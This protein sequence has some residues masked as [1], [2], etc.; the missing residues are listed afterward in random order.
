[1]LELLKKE[2]TD[3]ALSKTKEEI[4]KALKKE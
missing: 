2:M 3:Q 4:I 1:L